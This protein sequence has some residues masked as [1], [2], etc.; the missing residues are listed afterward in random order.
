MRKLCEPSGHVLRSVVEDAVFDGL[1]YHAIGSL[2]LAVAAWMG[3]R[4]VVDVDEVVLAKVPEVRPCKGLPHVGDNHVG[5][6]EPV[7]DVF[8]ELRSLFRR[9]YCNDADLNPLGEFVYCHQ[10]VL[11]AARGYLEGSH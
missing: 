4:G 8:N 5:Y 11:I 2:D 6:L 9:D 7:G 1:K 3:H 10:D